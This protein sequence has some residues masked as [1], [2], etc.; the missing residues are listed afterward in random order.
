MGKGPPPENL[1]QWS[2]ND[3]IR[4]LQ[5]LRAVMREHAEQPGADPREHVTP[6]AI[7]DVADDPHAR[8]GALLDARSATLLEGTDVVLVD[9]K[10]DEPVVMMMSLSGRVNYSHD[11]I[12]HA[13]LFGPDGAAA[14]VSELVGLAARAAGGGNHASRFATEFQERL[15]QR[16][17][18]LP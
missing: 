9:T 7:I 18:E 14:L 6:G 10:G 1:K 12:E 8:G 13:Y 17:S 4:E 3:L 16:M 15:D 5:R 2:K 11:R